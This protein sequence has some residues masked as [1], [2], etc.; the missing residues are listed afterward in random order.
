MVTLT[1]T[2][3]SCYVLSGLSVTDGSGNAVAVTWDGPFYNTATFTMPYSAVTVTPTF[4]NTL[5][6][7]GGLY[8]NMPA[9]GTKSATIPAG[10]QSF[11]VYD[12][13]G[14]GGTG[15]SYATHPDRP[16]GL[17]APALGQHDDGEL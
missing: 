10:V 9:T 4:T 5:T 3:E 15:Y 17:C 8:I 16:R 12:D 13:G 14:K 7:D 1:A 2:P 11:K 6:V